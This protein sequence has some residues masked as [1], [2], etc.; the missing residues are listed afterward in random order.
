KNPSLGQLQCEI[1]V[2]SIAL[3][4]S[5]P[6]TSLSERDA[7]TSLGSRLTPSKHLTY[8]YLDNFKFV[9]KKSQP[10]ITGKNG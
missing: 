3:R 2:Y 1:S 8:F 5:Q 7:T 9:N 6:M 10:I 4:S